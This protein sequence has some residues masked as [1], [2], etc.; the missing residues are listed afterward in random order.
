MKM[1]DHSNRILNRMLFQIS[2]Y[3]LGE[4]RLDILIDS[5]SGSI[6]AL[7]EKLPSEWKDSWTIQI[8][9]LDTYLALG[10]EE[11]KKSDI[12]EDLNQLDELIKELLPTLP[13][14]SL[15]D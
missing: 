1:N 4:I 3:R 5:L 15:S 9:N 10:L 6:D 7:E 14:S 12:L 8:V 13:N 2:K 11:G